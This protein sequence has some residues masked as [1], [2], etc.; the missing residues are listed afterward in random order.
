MGGSQA[1]AS[2]ATL[3]PGSNLLTNICVHFCCLSSQDKQSPLN[4]TFIIV[5]KFVSLG[6]SSTRLQA[7]AE[8]GAKVVFSCLYGNEYNN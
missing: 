8:G 6:K 5:F 2:P 3:T 7:T 1:S 4:V